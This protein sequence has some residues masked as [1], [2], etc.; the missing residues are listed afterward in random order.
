M[1]TTA[2]PTWSADESPN[3]S[4]CS[5]LEGTSTWITARSVVASEPTSFASAV[6]PSANV[7]LIDV[8]PSTTWWFVTMSPFEPI[9]KPEPWAVPEP[10]CGMPKGPLLPPP[11]DDVVTVISTTLRAERR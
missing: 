8:A 9:T 4:G 7:T 2:S 6:V 1:A 10:C 3:E 5:S 11:E